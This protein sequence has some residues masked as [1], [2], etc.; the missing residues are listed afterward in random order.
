MNHRLGGAALA[1]ALTVVSGSVF[2][3]SYDGSITTYSFDYPT[4][5]VAGMTQAN[6]YEALRYYAATQNR[7]IG[8]PDWVPNDLEIGDP[9]WYVC[10]DIA[11]SWNVAV[12]ASRGPAAFRD[13]LSRSADHGCKIEYTRNTTIDGNGSYE[14]L[15]VRPLR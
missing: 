15:S 1:V 13:L 11:Q 6:T 10:R 3:G 8:D 12:Q 14:L 7:L 4:S 2:G 9:D 5:S